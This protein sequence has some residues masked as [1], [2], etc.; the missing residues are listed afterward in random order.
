MYTGYKILIILQGILYF[1][2]FILNKNIK[3]CLTE[4]SDH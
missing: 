3:K 1:N 4:I 2:E